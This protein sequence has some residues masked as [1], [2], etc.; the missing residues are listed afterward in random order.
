[1]NDKQFINVFKLHVV[2][3][4]NLD[5]ARLRPQELKERDE[6]LRHSEADLVAAREV[7]REC[8]AEAERLGT[9]AAE[10]RVNMHDLFTNQEVQQTEVDTLRHEALELQQRLQEANACC[11]ETGGLGP[12]LPIFLNPRTH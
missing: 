12:L 7:A 1:M 5:A 6:L 4:R 11:E 3:T 8:G 9:E 2:I 10:L